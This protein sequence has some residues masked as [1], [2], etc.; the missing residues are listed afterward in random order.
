MGI[1]RSEQ[2]VYTNLPSVLSGEIES[3]VRVQGS[4]GAVALSHCLRVFR[5]G[6][7]SVLIFVT[8]NV[9]RFFI[10]RKIPKNNLIGCN[11]LRRGVSNKS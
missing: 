5:E 1:L 7:E 9:K 2:L 8:R 3:R 10:G 4:E 11:T 6:W